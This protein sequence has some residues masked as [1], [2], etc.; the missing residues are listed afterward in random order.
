MRSVS[1][2][3]KNVNVVIANVVRQQQQRRQN[4]GDVVVETHPSINHP[5]VSQGGW[6]MLRCQGVR[7]TRGA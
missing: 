3:N 7:V 5:R 1:Q 6:K 4:L 2:G